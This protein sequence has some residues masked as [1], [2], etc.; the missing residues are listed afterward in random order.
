MPVGLA[1][2]FIV[3]AIAVMVIAGLLY[4]YFHKG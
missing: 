3:L 4:V 1:A 2:C